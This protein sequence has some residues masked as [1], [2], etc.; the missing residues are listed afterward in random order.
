M[1]KSVVVYAHIIFWIALFGT[2][3]FVPIIGQRYYFSVNLGFLTVALTL[4]I[5][6]FFYAGYLF[7]MRINWRSKSLKVGA[8]V[9]LLVYLILFFISKKAFVYVTAPLPSF[10]LYVTIGSLFR[11][12]IDWFKKR[13]DVLVLE[14][15][16]VASNLAVLKSQI[17]P[18][19]L[20]NTLH[21]IDA[22]IYEDRDKASKSL[23]KLSD[24]M[25]YMLSDTQSD[26][27]DLQKELDYLQNYLALEQLRLK[28][29]RFLNY[30]VSGNLNGF[31][32]APMILIPFVENAFKHS[33]DSNIENGIIIKI[34]VN[35]N[36]LSFVCE[37]RFDP[38]DT[39]KD[40]GHGIGLENVK[41]RLSLIYSKKHN[42]TIN[43]ENAVFKV[44]LDIDLN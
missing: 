20:Y 17:N 39:D 36:R 34:D 9:A 14:K 12:F 10:F 41:K 21:N 43:T 22:L 30:S 29:E 7:V 32:I 31:K 26:F 24:I 15:E 38:S 23:E 11:F 28:S 40:K 18:H 5:P 2:K 19:F 27:V 6:V 16:N 8:L 42:L 4:L 33:V 3:L 35:K 44:N 13:N 37:N 25:R 1:K